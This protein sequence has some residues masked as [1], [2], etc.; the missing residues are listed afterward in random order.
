MAATVAVRSWCTNVGSGEWK[1]YSLEFDFCVMGV[2]PAFNPYGLGEDY[3]DGAIMFHVADMKE[4]FNERGIYTP[5]HPVR[6]RRRFLG[7]GLH[8]QRLL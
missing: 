6:P 7:A 8:V 4:S 1:D 5:L 3:H 2:D